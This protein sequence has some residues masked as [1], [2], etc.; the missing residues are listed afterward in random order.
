MQRMAPS[1]TATVS[2]ATVAAP[3]EAQTAQAAPSSLATSISTK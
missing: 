1:A 3:R 2:A